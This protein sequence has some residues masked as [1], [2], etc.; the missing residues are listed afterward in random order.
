M[1]NSFKFSYLLVVIVSVSACSKSFVVVSDIPRPL[2]PISPLTAHLKY[3]DEFKNFEYIDSSKK[4]ALEKV[5]FGAAQVNLFDQIFS[6]LFTVVDESSPADLVIEPQVLDFQ[7][8]IPAETKSTQYEVWLK[9][10]LKITN[11]DNADIADWVVKGYGKTPKSLL[12]SHLK[13]FNVASNIALRDVGA[14]LAIGFKTQPSIKDFIDNGV[15]AITPDDGS[16]DE[17]KQMMPES[18]ANF[19]EQSDQN[20]IEISDTEPVETAPAT[21][22][23]M[24]A[25]DKQNATESEFNMIELGSIELDDLSNQANILARESQNE[26]IQ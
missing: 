10:R 21:Q 24:E 26:E 9:Y 15:I 13:L 20:A 19:A 17:P 2:I 7:Y 12:V 22:D 3:S 18:T 16:E 1:N 23:K 8:S 11:G 14:Q 5:Q 25:D 6:S 4:R